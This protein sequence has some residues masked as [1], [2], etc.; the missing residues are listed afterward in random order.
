[1][2]VDSWDLFCQLVSVHDAHCDIP[3]PAGTESLE[4]R[5]AG[6]LCKLVC[7]LHGAG[8]TKHYHRCNI[9]AFTVAVSMEA[10]NPIAAEDCIGHCVYTRILV[11]AMRKPRINLNCYNTPGLLDDSVV[12]ISLIRLAYFVKLGPKIHQDITC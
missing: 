9:T 10:P 6:S 4:T 3:V 2:S 11:R 7:F 5:P 12:A 8:R 1:M